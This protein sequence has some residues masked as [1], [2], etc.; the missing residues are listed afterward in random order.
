MGKKFSKEE[1]LLEEYKLL[2]QL[3]TEESHF[4]WTR[5]NVIFV[6]NSFLLSICAFLIK[7][8]YEMPKAEMIFYL[9]LCFSC[10]MGIVI[11]FVWFIVTER[12]RTFKRLW[13][14]LSRNIE[15]NLEVEVSG[16]KEQVLKTHTSS[17]NIL[18]KGDVSKIP[19]SYQNRGKIILASLRW[20]QK[21]SINKWISVIIFFFFM[22]WIALI[23]LLVQLQINNWCL[24]G[25]LFSICAIP[26][27]LYI[28][29]I[30]IAYCK[31]KNEEKID[32][33]RN[34][35]PNFIKNIQ[36]GTSIQLSDITKKYNIEVK[37]LI[38]VIT[39]LIKTNKINAIMDL[40]N[41]Q[42]IVN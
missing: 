34:D 16:K 4:F 24:S 6:L 33:I 19:T 41:E 20:G 30:C 21:R 36:K 23:P 1:I 32:R 29:D 42:L 22:F 37:I 11:T 7:L 25:P 8:F 5:F 40:S 12:G 3:I 17:Y 26:L 31:E 13:A 15:E 27:I 38:E 14:D 39:E 35:F 9:I 10:A 28:I 18:S 2:N